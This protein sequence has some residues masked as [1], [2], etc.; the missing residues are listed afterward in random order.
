[1]PTWLK[2]VLGVV[3][4]AVV[5]F[6]LLIAG[7][8]YWFKAHKGELV[9][10]GMGAMQEGQKFGQGQ[11]RTAC[12]AEGLRRLPSVDGLTGEVK[13]NLFT[14]GCLDAADDSP[15]FCDGVPATGEI[16]N[17]V[18]WRAG[19]CGQHAELDPQRCQ[20]FLQ[21]W[22]ESCHGRASESAQPH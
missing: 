20:R 2:V 10:A 18:K 15:G 5:L 19:V 13:N 6:A 14:R 12:I 8:V 9:Q 21:T 4:A 11:Q 7:G 22:Q 17:T 1:M 16:M 3:V